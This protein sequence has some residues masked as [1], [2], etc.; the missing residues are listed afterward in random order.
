MLLCCITLR[1]NAFQYIDSDLRGGSL[2]NLV[3]ALI[4]SFVIHMIYILSPILIGY[5]KTILYKPD[6]TSAQ[7]NVEYLQ[8][9][10]A[11][12]GII[13]DGSGFL[14]ISYLFVTMVCGFSIILYKK[15]MSK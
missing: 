12:G 9:E 13:T 6:L 1:L 5:V 15:F 2:K 14:L 11:F 7:D 8:N 4:G 10:V 3:L